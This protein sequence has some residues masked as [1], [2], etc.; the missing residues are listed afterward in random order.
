M[1]TASREQPPSRRI[2]DALRQAIERG[3]YAAG[4]K[5]P[6]ER[7]LAATYRSARNTAREAIGILQA[8]GLLD[9]QH[10]KGAFVRPAAR[11]IRLGAN[12]YSHRLR[13]ETG[14][15]PF[16]AE[17]RRAGK[18]ARVEVPEIRRVQPPADVAERLEVPV[19]EPSVVQ[20]SNHYF[21][22]DEPVQIGVTYIPWTIAGDTVLATDATAPGAR[23]TS[24]YAEF[25]RLGYRL[26]KVREEITA[27]MPR[28]DEV[29]TLQIP[30][31]VP[32]IQVLHTGY[33]H[34]DRP[35]EV[36]RF[37]MRADLNGLDYWLPV[38][39]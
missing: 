36:S 12:R 28:P 33:D 19:D 11:M 26:A 39:D 3:D 7:V 13:Q 6:S 14:L 25:E 31:G 16:R 18:T 27:R 20:R 17:A 23:L 10:G 22:D 34:H 37:T 4:D 24:I 1:T 15:S 5:L 35:F 29:V 9:V 30:P 21:A 8:E 38:E 2:A 32:V